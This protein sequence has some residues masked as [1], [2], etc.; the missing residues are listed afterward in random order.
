MLFVELM[1]IVVLVPPLVKVS[2]PWS[3]ALAAV[4]VE[5]LSKLAWVRS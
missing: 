4:T 2:V 1:E 3:I 5:L